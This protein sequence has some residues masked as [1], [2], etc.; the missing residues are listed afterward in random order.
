MIKTIISALNL[1]SGTLSPSL[2]IIEMALWEHVG[3]QSGVERL[4]RS[5][6]VLGFAQGSDY[7]DLIDRECWSKQVKNTVRQL[8]A[9]N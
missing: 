3:D 4:R 7:L 8:L 1:S 6:Q 9:A 5:L 2:Q